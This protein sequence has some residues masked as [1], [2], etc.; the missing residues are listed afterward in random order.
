MLGNEVP[1]LL[2]LSVLPLKRWDSGVPRI[3]SIAGE[4]QLALATVNPDPS[5]L[6]LSVLPDE[7]AVA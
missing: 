6:P 5:F 1:E 7:S 4:L 3:A 2:S